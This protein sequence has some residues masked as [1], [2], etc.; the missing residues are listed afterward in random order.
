M[1]V[2]RP[3]SL[4]RRTEAGRHAPSALADW[5]MRAEPV[6]PQSVPVSASAHHLFAQPT[7]ADDPQPTPLSIR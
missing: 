5:G 4:G 2:A 6:S 3:D 7:R 1:S